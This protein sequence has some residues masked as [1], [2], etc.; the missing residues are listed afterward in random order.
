MEKYEGQDNYQIVNISRSQ[1]TL[2][3]KLD[4]MRDGIK[5]QL[6]P[7][8]L[9]NKDEKLATAVLTSQFTN[10]DN[11]PISNELIVK[12]LYKFNTDLPISQDG[13]EKVKVQNYADLLS[14]FDTAIGILRG[15][16]FEWLQ[17]SSLQQ[18]LPF[19]EIEEFVKDIRISFSK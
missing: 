10:A 5:L 14:I 12:I 11:Q 1:E 9:L 8:L 7:Y 13:V 19:V 4:D 17:G 15:I 2:S 16:L 3:I 6:L 18:P